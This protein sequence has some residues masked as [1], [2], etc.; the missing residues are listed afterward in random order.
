MGSGMEVH[1]VLN[2]EQY[3]VGLKTVN[4]S[5]TVKSAYNEHLCAGLF[6]RFIRIFSINESQKEVLFDFGFGLLF[7]ISG[8]SV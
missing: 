3:N 5:L 2:K 8:C 1:Y 4:S 7:I 6:V